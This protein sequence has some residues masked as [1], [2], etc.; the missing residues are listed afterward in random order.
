[1]KKLLSISAL[2]GCN[3]KWTQSSSF[4]NR[5]HSFPLP[6]CRIF[7][8]KSLRGSQAM[9]IPV[10]QPVKTEEDISHR[11]LPVYSE[12]QSQSLERRKAELWDELPVSLESGLDKF[13]ERMEVKISHNFKLLRLRFYLIW[14]W[15]TTKN[16]LTIPLILTPQKVFITNFRK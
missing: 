7:Q 9:F 10:P 11:E 16:N 13:L 14:T 12:L 8:V 1:M 4:E 3:T 2:V 15:K 6:E 5:A